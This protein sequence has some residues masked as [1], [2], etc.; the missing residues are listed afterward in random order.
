[1]GGSDR[2][3]LKISV[4]PPPPPPFHLL[5]FVLLLV[6]LNTAKRFY[7]ESAV[8]WALYCTT[9]FLLPSLSPLPV[10]FDILL[11]L[12]ASPSSSDD[13]THT[14]NIREKRLCT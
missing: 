12:L 7:A 4:S 5:F 8:C 10:L 1:M 3:G 13:R 2:I 6:Q 14:H 9:L 11:L